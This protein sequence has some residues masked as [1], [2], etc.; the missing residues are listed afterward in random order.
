MTRI[1]LS[2]SSILLAGSAIASP[3]THNQLGYAHKIIRSGATMTVE[4]TLKPKR[5]F[6][7]VSVQ[8]GSGVAS[9]SPDCSFI[10]VT[11]GGSYVCRFDVTGKPTDAAMTVNIVAESTPAPHALVHAEIHHLTMPNSTFVRSAA[12]AAA[13]KHTLISSRPSSK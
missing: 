13:S 9:I 11:V 10:G 4:I 7:S 8:A 2:L 6:D 5:S 3:P 1:A 12:A